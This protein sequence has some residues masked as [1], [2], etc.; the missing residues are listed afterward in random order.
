MPGAFLNNACVGPEG[1]TPAIHHYFVSFIDT[2]GHL[3]MLR[4]CSRLLTL[5]PSLQ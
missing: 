2:A 1:A 3:T 5:G 4:L